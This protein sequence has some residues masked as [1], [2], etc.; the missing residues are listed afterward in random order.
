MAST[1]SAP[2]GCIG[3]LRTA[4]ADPHNYPSP[5]QP[6]R[7][8][9]NSRVFD[10]AHGVDSAQR[11]VYP[12]VYKQSR[13]SVSRSRALKMWGDFLGSSRRQR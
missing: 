3:G 6:Q 4:A 5:A 10:G 12:Q 13:V 2:N 7:R 11:D 9:A 1:T 8:Q